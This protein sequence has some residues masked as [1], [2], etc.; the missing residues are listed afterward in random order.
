MTLVLPESR[1][2]RKRVSIRMWRAG[3]FV[4]FDP[5]IC[6]WVSVENDSIDSWNVATEKYT[7]TEMY[8]R[9]RQSEIE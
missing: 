9:W 8:R 1:W 5:A 7:D 3:T 2:D 6:K 4:S